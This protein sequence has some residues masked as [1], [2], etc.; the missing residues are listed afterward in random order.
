MTEKSITTGHKGR[1]GERWRQEYTIQIESVRL[2]WLISLYSACLSYAPMM[3]TPETAEHH[4]TARKLQNTRKRTKNA[5][6]FLNKNKSTA[7]QSQS[8]AV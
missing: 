8:A 4:R 5:Q 1:G 6:H 7:H 2:W 3:A